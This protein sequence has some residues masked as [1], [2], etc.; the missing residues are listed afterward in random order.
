MGLRDTFRPIGNS[1]SPDHAAVPYLAVFLVRRGFAFAKEFSVSR[2]GGLLLCHVAGGS[3]A[4]ASTDKVVAYWSDELHFKAGVAMFCADLGLGDPEFTGAAIDVK[5]SPDR[6]WKRYKIGTWILAVAAFFGALSAL[7][8]YYQVMFAVPEVELSHSDVKRIDVIEG[9]QIAASVSAL[10]EVRFATTTVKFDSA[11]LQPRSGGAAV[12]LRIAPP[13]LANLST[14]KQEPATAY[15]PAPQLANNGEAPDVYDLTVTGTARA[16]MFRNPRHHVQTEKRELWVWP[17]KA[18]FG[19]KK[20]WLENRVCSLRETLYNPVARPDGVSALITLTSRSAE[21]IDMYV[22]APGTN[23]PQPVKKESG[24]MT[25]RTSEFKTPALGNFSQY[26]I[27]VSLQPLKSAT[28]DC[29]RFFQGIN[30][31]PQ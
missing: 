29:D 23:V 6:F 11:L 9:D 24:G 10:S 22:A 2:Y 13:M 19:S 16:G 3:G 25:T 30:I 21:V 15:G 7:R 18:K 14:G 20:I 8:D 12:K 5:R 27:K 28:P 26:F 17:R 4:G 31:T 1:A